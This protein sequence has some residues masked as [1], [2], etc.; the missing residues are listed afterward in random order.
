MLFY[1]ALIA[2]AAWQTN[3]EPSDVD[4][5]ICTHSTI[6]VFFC[7]AFF[8]TGETVLHDLNNVCCLQACV[9]LCTVV[10]LYSITRFVPC[11]KVY[12]Y[13]I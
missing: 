1:Y 8:L 13:S 4:E 10:M 12:N 2:R 6:H 3:M 7:H 5:E 11:K 9:T